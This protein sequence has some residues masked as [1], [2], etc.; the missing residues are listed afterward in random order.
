MTE[1]ET[2]YS[3]SV[4]PCL[5]RHLLPERSL[6]PTSEDRRIPDSNSRVRKDRTC[7]SAYFESQ[8]RQMEISIS[9]HRFYKIMGIRHIEA[10]TQTRFIC[11]LFYITG[12]IVR[13]FASIDSLSCFHIHQAPHAPRRTPAHRIAPFAESPCSD[14][15]SR[16]RAGWRIRP[17]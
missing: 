13:F 12:I 16:S 1:V 8:I 15:A 4:P 10:T 6:H 9:T 3:L 5:T 2:K 14:K 7:G 11:H 17:D